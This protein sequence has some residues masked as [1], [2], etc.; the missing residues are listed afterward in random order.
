MILFI[1]SKTPEYR[2]SKQFYSNLGDDKTVTSRVCSQILN[3]K[4]KM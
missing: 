3:G 4:M 2:Y 1:S